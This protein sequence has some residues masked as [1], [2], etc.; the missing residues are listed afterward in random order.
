MAAKMRLSSGDVRRTEAAT[1]LC[2]TVSSHGDWESGVAMAT[3]DSRLNAPKAQLLKPKFFSH[4]T[5]LHTQICA[6]TFRFDFRQGLNGKAK[7]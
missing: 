1:W 7:G 4:E 5:Y 6:S 2:A 3:H